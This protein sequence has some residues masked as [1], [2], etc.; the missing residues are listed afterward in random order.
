[1]K[2][3]LKHSL[4]TLSIISLSSISSVLY[5]QE[6]ENLVPNPSF[7]SI[8]KSPKKLGSIE[9][10]TGWYSGTSAKADL[11]TSSKV[12]DIDVPMNSL[13]KEEA[14]DGG[15]YAGIRV[16][17]HGG[18]ESRSYVLTKLDVPMKKGMKYCVKFYVSLAEASK[19]ATNNVGVLFSKKPQ[20]GEQKTP[21]FEET[22]VVHFEN[23]L[24]VISG[25]FGWAEVCGVYIAEGGEKYI[26]IGN[27]EG[28]DDTRKERMKK[29]T[30]VKTSQGTSAYYYLDN[31]SVVLLNSDETCAC[32]TEAAG[33]EY[34][35]MIYQKSFNTTDDM[36]AKEQ[37]EEHSVYFA[38]GKT[39]LS[40]EGISTLDFIAEKMKEDAVLKLEIQGHSNTLEDSV[41]VEND[42][43]AYM[44]NKRIGVVLEYLK[45]KGIPEGRLL[46]SAKGAGVPSKD[47]D[48]TDDEELAMAKSRRVTFKVR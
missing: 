11:F 20:G 15:N 35:K 42:Y 4:L 36:S 23:D 26:T 28:N 5:S 12:T 29:S 34:S 27:F 44:D 2:F 17:S 30:D 33:E 37:I 43:Y 21:I 9:S 13:G 38:F 32:Q 10:A 24:K 22:S 19:Y 7:E 47:V 46:Y 45:E 3:N 41:G 16:Y 40:A 39:K 8:G 31:I 14:M 48:D 18:K 6:G 25:R 1:M